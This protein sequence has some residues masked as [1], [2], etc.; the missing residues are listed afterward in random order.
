M[1]V[2]TEIEAE[3]TE[4]VSQNNTALKKIAQILQKE[5]NLLSPDIKSVNIRRVYLI[6]NDSNTLSDQAFKRS[7]DLIIKFTSLKK[8]L[9]EQ[10]K[11][12]TYL[13]L[14]EGLT[15]ELNDP[16]Y[17]GEDI[18]RIVNHLKNIINSPQNIIPE[19]VFGYDPNI[20]R[21]QDRILYAILSTRTDIKDAINWYRM[22]NSPVVNNC[23]PAKNRKPRTSN[24]ST[25]P[26]NYKYINTTKH[27]LSLT[28]TVT[29]LSYK[30]VFPFLLS[31]TL[32]FTLISSIYL[33]RLYNIGTSI[34]DSLKTQ[35]FSKAHYQSSLLNQ[36]CK[37]AQSLSASISQ[38]IP[39]ISHR[40]NII[41]ACLDMSETLMEFSYMANRYYP[42][43]NNIDLKN[44]AS[45][46]NKLTTSW[47]KTVIHLK[48]PTIKDLASAIINTQISDTGL[49]SITQ[50]LSVLAE[51]S[52]SLDSYI[53][54]E[55]RLR[56]AILFQN[57]N[58]LRPTG[59]FI[60]S[61]GL[62]NI[63]PDFSYELIIKDVYDIDGKLMGH[64]NP[65]SP[66]V[67]YLNQ[68]AWYL[69]DSNWSPDFPTS[70]QNIRWF[71]KKSIDYEPE[72]LIAIDTE[73]LKEFL[74]IFGPVNA[75]DLSAQITENNLQEV[76]LEHIETDFFP[77]S[78]R[79]TNILNEIYTDIKFKLI[80]ATPKQIISVNEQIHRLL[81]NKHILITTNNDNVNN[82]LTRYNWNGR[83]GHVASHQTDR[84]NIYYTPVEANL[85]VNKANKFVDRRYEI[86][87]N[88]ES[89]RAFSEL[90][91]I[92]QNNSKASSKLEGDYR[93]YLQIPEQTI[94][95]FTASIITPYEKFIISPEIHI[96][97][98][99]KMYGFPYMILHNSNAIF[100]LNQVHELTDLYT[101]SFRKQPGTITDPITIN[102]ND[103]F[104]RQIH[105]KDLTKGDTLT[106]NTSLTYNTQLNTDLYI[107]IKLK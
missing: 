38:I 45:E 73:V 64:V 105:F 27:I 99:H 47:K 20:L 76:L 46:M 100:Q 72:V 50:T 44:L 3:L 87:L 68:P 83:I 33:Y 61:V 85:G 4:I 70:F 11:L 30:K 6:L 77:G 39:E 37:I 41:T 53:P 89:N 54:V 90:R 106:H 82:F 1:I 102:V 67:Q 104:N 97:S 31:S 29:Q 49:A 60:G 12:Y 36:Q 21:N 93:N 88:L 81:S 23:N 15:K 24:V 66:I 75:T 2:K 55:D 58:E 28:R 96:N 35:D 101:I 56:I 16:N 63:N 10:N 18:N 98:G 14:E 62:L 25:K 5:Y 19:I 26:S 17:N 103:S 95:N 80:S 32:I 92:Y 69:R 74:K 43:S 107:S 71:L 7:K 78:R 94:N 9:S 48:D 91:I 51:I 42:P 13:V 84:T 8:Y 86:D 65:P 59:G 22:T 40:T 34:R 57:N 79:K 52:S